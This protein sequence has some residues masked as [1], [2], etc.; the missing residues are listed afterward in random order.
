VSYQLQYCDSLSTDQW[1]PVS[2]AWIGGDGGEYC[3]P[4]AVEVAVA[5]RYYRLQLQSK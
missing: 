3:L 4:E 2:D 1:L 5:E